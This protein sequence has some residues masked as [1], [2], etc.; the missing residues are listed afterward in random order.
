MWTVQKV[1]LVIFII[2]KQVIQMCESYLKMRYFLIN[3]LFVGKTSIQ[4]LRSNIVILSYFYVLVNKKLMTTTPEYKSNEDNSY[5]L[6]WSKRASSLIYWVQ[7]RFGPLEKIRL[8]VNLYFTAFYT[9][10]WKYVKLLRV[11][12][13]FDYLLPDN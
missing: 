2:F 6:Y 3:R 11:Y 4:I 12:S 1:I 7:K 5:S 10:H 9:I 13:F 8:I